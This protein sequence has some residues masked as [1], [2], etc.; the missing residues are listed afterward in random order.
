MGARQCGLHPKIGD[1]VAVI[2]KDRVYPALLG[3]A[4]PSDKI[5][6]A[7]LRLARAL[8]PKADGQTRAIEELAVTYLYFPG[9]R[10][11]FGE[12]DLAQWRE[13][14]SSLLADIGGLSDPADLHDWLAEE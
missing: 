5:G 13:K 4:G 1:Y 9:S 6:E 8:N 12:P 2:Y 14:V 10:A 7:S 3:D 11:A